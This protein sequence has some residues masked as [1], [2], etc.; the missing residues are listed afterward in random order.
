MRISKN[1][2]S[3]TRMNT[4]FAGTK[5]TM[6]FEFYWQKIENIIIDGATVLTQPMNSMVGN[7]GDLLV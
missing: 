4:G 6:K 3:E 5:I 2:I 1:T 7:V